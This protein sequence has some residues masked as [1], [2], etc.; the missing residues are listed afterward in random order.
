MRRLIII[1]IS[2]MLKLMI[3]LPIHYMSLL[4]CPLILMFKVY[5]SLI[6][7][8]LIGIEVDGWH[9]RRIILRD[10]ARFDILKLASNGVVGMSGVGHSLVGLWIDQVFP[11]VGNGLPG[12]HLAH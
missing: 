7:T 1:N 3:I 9:K 8:E 5:R 11:A 2:H 6:G 12:V 10:D 4:N